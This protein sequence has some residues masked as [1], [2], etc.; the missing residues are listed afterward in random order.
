MVLYLKQQYIAE[1]TLMTK[2]WI[3]FSYLDVPKLFIIEN[4]LVNH[5]FKK[6]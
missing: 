3:C 5:C 4:S 6:L 1:L 2:L